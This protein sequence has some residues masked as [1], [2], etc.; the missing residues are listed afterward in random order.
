MRFITIILGVMLFFCVVAADN[1]PKG[2]LICDKMAGKI[3]NTV[4]FFYIRMSTGAYGM[5]RMC[6]V[7]WFMWMSIAS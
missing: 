1:D 6:D 5:E 2:N 7:L 4:G 3:A